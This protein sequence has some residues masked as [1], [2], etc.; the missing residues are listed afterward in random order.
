MPVSKYLLTGLC[1]GFLLLS[2]LVSAFPASTTWLR[3][4]FDQPS[5]IALDKQGQAYVLDGVRGRVVVFDAQGKRLFQFGSPGSKEGQLQLAMDI[6]ISD[7]L[8]YIADTGNHR[9]SIFDLQGRFQRHI[10]LPMLEQ[11]AAQPVALLVKDQ[12]IIWSDRRHHRLCRTNSQSGKT[13]T[14]W[15]QRGEGKADFNFPFMLAL[16]KDDYIYAVDVLNSRVKLFNLLGHGFGLISRFGLAEGGLIRPNGITLDDN[17]RLFV[18]DSYTGQVAV[19]VQRQFQGWLQDSQGQ[20]ILFDS[21]VG[22]QYQQGRLYVVEA[23]R[24]QVVILSLD[25]VQIGKNPVIPTNAKAKLSRKNCL[26]CHLS[27]SQNYTFSKPQPVLPVATEAMCYSC[28]HGAV[29]DSRARIGHGEQHPHSSPADKP[30]EAPLP[31]AFPQLKTDDGDTL[32]CGSCHTPHAI[33]EDVLAVHEGHE[34][35][36]MRVANKDGSLCHQCHK[37]YDDNS[38]QGLNHPVG[39]HLQKPPTAGDKNY[40]QNPDLY[41]GLPTELSQQN[42]RLGE[43]KQLICAT[44][45]QI[46]GGEVDTR[47]LVAPETQLCLSCHQQQTNTKAKQNQHGLN[48]P[49]GIRLQKPPTAGDKNYTQNPDLYTGL[50]AE[51]EQQGARLGKDKELICSTCHQA[52]GGKADTRLLIMPSPKLCQSCHQQQTN[53]D[54]KQAR[55][56]GQHPAELALDKP[57]QLGEQKITQLTCDTCHQPHQSLADSALLTSAVKD[58]QSLCQTCHERQYAKD[59]ETAKTQGIHPV[60]MTLDEEVTLAGKK[61]KR[62]NCNSCHATHQGKKNTPA[63]VED[64]RQGQLCAACHPQQQAVLASDHHLKVTASDSLNQLEQ[65]PAQAGACGTCHSLH[66]GTPEWPFLY[67]GKHFEPKIEG[68]DSL[69]MRDKLCLSCHS[70]KQSAET[71]TIKLFSHPYQDLVLRS[72]P[73]I[74]PLLDEQEKIS[75]F[76]RIACI[77]CHAPHHWDGESSKTL[78]QLSA[79]TKDLNG[80]I[81]NSF[82]RQSDVNKT[83]CMDCHGLES[84]LKYQFY[85]HER[86]RGMGVDY[87]K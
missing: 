81:N 39:I 11:V 22:L 7:Q 49:V 72:D 79:I 16:D 75:R 42:A 53:A 44:C 32:Y 65:K 61:I 73:K 34:N 76:G 48:H 85:H 70:D 14:C 10:H 30:R 2:Q 41:T 64:H 36:W 1:L 51:L 15:G 26:T 83:F 59:K 55:R 57:V 84:R 50:P 20:N 28:H 67:I 62:V 33:H 58:Q 54:A 31:K 78:H 52:H 6:H 18:S 56:K 4:D 82:L 74:L 60:N 45:H 43:K 77:T 19:F 37:D 9:L 38:Q 40:T 71:K 25:D 3:T 5:A 29:I 17:A 46:H 68:G 80:D 27:W 87:L 35:A 66:Q 12:Q 86:S 21:P 47:L 13:K 69:L 63:L 23:R 24:N 8:I